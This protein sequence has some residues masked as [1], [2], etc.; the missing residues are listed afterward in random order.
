LFIKLD[1]ASWRALAPAG[2]LELIDS[3]GR[4]AGNEGYFGVHVKT[5]DGRPVGQWMR[6]TGA[7]LLTT[8]PG[9]AS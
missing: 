3:L 8:T 9:G 5:N 6:K 2:K 7:E 1:A 4:L